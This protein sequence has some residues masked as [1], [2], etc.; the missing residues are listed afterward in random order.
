MRRD[1]DEEREDSSEGDS[2]KFR[3]LNFL[4]GGGADAP[5]KYLQGFTAQVN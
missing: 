5:E 4:C 3:K 1:G 2:L